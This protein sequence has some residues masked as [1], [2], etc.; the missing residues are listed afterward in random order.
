M[1]KGAIEQLL[2][3][4]F[5]SSR[6]SNQPAARPQARVR[7]EVDIVNI[8]Y[9][10]IQRFGGWLGTC[11]FIDHHIAYKIAQRVGSAIVPIRRQQMGAA[12]ARNRQR[13]QRAVV[14]LRIEHTAGGIEIAVPSRKPGY[15]ELGVRRS[16]HVAG[17]ATDTSLPRRAAQQLRRAE[18]DISQHNH[19]GLVPAGGL[20][21]ENFA[22]TIER[23]ITEICAHRQRL[24]T[25]PEGGQP[26]KQACA[27]Q[28]CP[29]DH[30][31]T[32]RFAVPVSG[33]SINGRWFSG[34]PSKSNIDRTDPAS[35]SKEPAPAAGVCSSM[36]SRP[37]FCS[38]KRK[39]EV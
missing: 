12:Q 4:L 34:L 21:S 27:S 33:S 3:V 22:R 8:S 26:C 20:R 1:R 28:D 38:M 18:R 6:S 17:T 13:L 30:R 37:Q 35:R 29:P 2:A 10:R 25:D 23:G 14:C 19:V 15:I 7:H 39:L 11:K 24:G 31:L 32:Y 5:C 9:E 36:Y 16:I